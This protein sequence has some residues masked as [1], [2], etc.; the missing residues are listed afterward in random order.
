M[1]DIQRFVAAAIFLA[2][3]IAAYFLAGA[4]VYESGS[5]GQLAT[6]QGRAAAPVESANTP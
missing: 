1:E 2:V 6:H 4:F 5:E 3:F